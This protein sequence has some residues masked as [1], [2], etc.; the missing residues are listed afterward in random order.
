MAINDR[1][2]L[3]LL[4]PDDLLPHIGK[5]ISEVDFI[6]QDLKANFPLKWSKANLTK[7]SRNEYPPVVWGSGCVFIT[8]DGK[9]W[10]DFSSQTHNLHLGHNHPVIKES[11]SEYLASDQ[12]FFSSSMFSNIPAL[13]FADLLIKHTPDELTKVNLK[14][15][16]GAGAIEF[17]LRSAI[18]YHIQNGKKNFPILS[19]RGSYHGETYLNLRVTHREYEK[20]DL[21]NIQFHQIEPNNIESFKNKVNELNPVAL[22]LEPII[23]DDGVVVLE[24][25][26]L[27]QIRNICD[28]KD[29]CLIYDEVQTGG[30]WL[31]SFTAAEHFQVVPDIL[32]L[33]KAFTAGWPLA[34]VLTKKKYDVLNYTEGAFTAGMNPLVCEIGIKN[35]SYIFKCNLLKQSNDLGEYLNKSINSVKDKYAEITKV[36][37]LGLIQGIKFNSQ[38]LA[39]SI[40][41]K[42]LRNGVLVRL[43]KRGNGDTIILKP[44]VILTRKI[45]NEF[46]IS[47]DANIIKSI[48]H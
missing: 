23:V 36:E 18:T 10:L 2:L 14:L 45:I 27:Q 9:I 19:M 24:K 44:P 41:E 38:T 21:S 32:I 3:T 6:D 28:E 39:N 26:Y 31:G 48:K 20:S 43:S 29:I 42:C 12:P 7:G 4:K 47:F 37:G 11:I 35:L 1:E 16:S 15:L 13:E 34:A 22:I 5:N 30:G 46:L 40:Y 25:R 17:G 33:A 8:A